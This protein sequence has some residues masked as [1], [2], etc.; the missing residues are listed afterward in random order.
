MT[1]LTKGII[2]IDGFVI[3]PKTNKNDLI[4]TYRD[5]LSPISAD[6]MIR[7][8]RL[9]NIYGSLF[10]CLFCFDD[11]Y[12]IQSLKLTPFIE[13]KSEE[14]DRTGQQEERREFCDK[15]LFDRLGAP[16]KI[17]NRDIEYSYTNIRISCFSNYDI[18]HGANA[19]YIVIE[20]LN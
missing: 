1:D 14:G 12:E 3:T 8:N 7:F 20:Y 13:Y 10:G 11:E 16:H 2:E 9:F 15:W 4:N 6:K 5:K 19:G 17:L 18:H